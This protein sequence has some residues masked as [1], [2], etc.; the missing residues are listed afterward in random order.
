MPIKL[1]T[2]ANVLCK[3]PFGE[4]ATVNKCSP[5]QT[6]PEYKAA[7]AAPGHLGSAKITNPVPTELGLTLA[8]IL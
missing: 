5:L 4:T 7:A 8:A 3:G 6:A 1:E 2:F